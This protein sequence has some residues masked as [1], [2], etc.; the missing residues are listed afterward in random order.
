M[1]D[2]VTSILLVDDEMDACRNLA[3]IFEDLGYQV[4]TA[5]SGEDALALAKRRR[6]DIAFLD[7]MMPGMDGA[8][9]ALELKKEQAGTVTIIVT[10]HPSSPR[11]VAA[12]GP[13]QK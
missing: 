13:A 2:K 7:L 10:A 3:D 1:S 5:A 8:T 6:Y 9:L 12:L 11:A 4:D